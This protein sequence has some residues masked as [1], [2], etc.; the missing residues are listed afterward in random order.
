M[1]QP[2]RS[3][4]ITDSFFLCSRRR[5]NG[6]QVCVEMGFAAVALRYAFPVTVY[7]QNCATDSRGRS[8]TMQSISSSL[9]V[10]PISRI[11]ESFNFQWPNFPFSFATCPDIFHSKNVLFCRKRSTPRTSW[12]TRS[13]T[14]IRSTSSTLSTAPVSHIPHKF[15]AGI[16]AG[17]FRI[18]L[19][20][21]IV[22]SLPVPGGQ[23]LRSSG[24][25]GRHTTYD[26]DES[27]T[28][29][30]TPQQAAPP[31][32][33]TTV[34]VSGHQSTPNSTT[35]TSSSVSISAG[36]AP[37]AT[38]SAPSG[39]PAPSRLTYTEK[40]MLLSSDDEFQWAEQLHSILLSLVSTRQ[41]ANSGIV[42]K[43][44]KHKQKKE[45]KREHERCAALLSSSRRGGNA[46]NTRKF[47]HT[48][49][50]TK[51]TNFSPSLLSYTINRYISSFFS[52]PISVIGLICREGNETRN[53]RNADF[54]Q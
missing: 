53:G 16:L 37:A 51:E 40:T 7:A 33:H 1:W 44:R 13:T 5:E 23:G 3:E 46:K 42:E 38:G 28:S 8:V 54:T 9:K 45:K 15:V 17:Y 31:S 36:A 26:G 6:E 49:T 25:N 50:H 39:H 19:D 2:W 14:S 41:W 20:P 43:T 4:V 47:T 18:S 21:Q 52:T 30:T 11:N 10:Q 34:V 12:P 27:S 24:R 35:S 22:P 32:G 48:D 29:R